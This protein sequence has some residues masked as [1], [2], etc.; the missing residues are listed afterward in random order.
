MGAYFG[1][2][3]ICQYDQIYNTFSKQCEEEATTTTDTAYQTITPETLSPVVISP[4]ECG[5]P[6]GYA[7][8]RLY[9]LSE[10]GRF[11]RSILGPNSVKTP[12]AQE[13]PWQVTIEGSDGCSGAIISSTVCFF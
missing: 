3:C 8:N 10:N 12:S 6:R 11:I 7:K 4:K 1:A 9:V 5:R 13:N 2:K